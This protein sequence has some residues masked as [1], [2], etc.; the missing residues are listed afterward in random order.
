MEKYSNELN[1]SGGCMLKREA[2]KLLQSALNNPCATFREGQWEAINSVV[3]QNKKVL[4]IQRTGWGKSAVYFIASKI[5]RDRG[6]GMSVIISPLLA[7]MRN[8]VEAAQRLGIS[9]VTLNSSN[10]YD[11]ESIQQRIFRQEVDCLLI[12]PE[13]LGNE[14]F[15]NE[16]LQ[17]I[18]AH[19]ALMVVDEAHC[20]SD[21][22]H[23]FRPDYRRIVGILRRMPPNTPVLCTTATANNRVIQDIQ[24]QIGQ[25]EIQRGSLIR[26]TLHL[27]TLNMP[28][29][30]ERLTWL[31]QA[32]RKF[33][34]TGIVYTLTTRDAEKVAE[35][36][37]SNGINAVAYYSGITHPDFCSSDDYR[38]HLEQA[39]QQN[40]LKVLVATSALGMGYDKPDI[41]FVIHY[42]MPN[43]V[44]GYYQQVGRAGRGVSHALGVL[45][46][47]QEDE[48]IQAFFRNN[49]FPT[50]EEINLVL[51]ALEQSDGLRISDLQRQLNLKRGTIDKVLKFLNL[52]EPAPIIKQKAYW[53]RTVHAYKLD[54]KRIAQLTEQRIKEWREMQNYLQTNQCKMN[55]LQSVLDDCY[56]Q[57]CGKCD[58]CLGRSVV[59]ITIDPHILAQAQ[60]FLRQSEIVIVPRKQFKTAI[61][62]QYGFSGKIPDLLRNEQGRILARWGEEGWGELVE[63]GEQEGYFSDELVEAMAEMILKRWKPMPTPR[64]LCAVPSLRHPTLVVDF[65]QRLAHRLN[66]PFVDC[67]QK[68]KDNSPQKIQNNS[69][70]QCQNLDGVFTVKDNL[71]KTPA[72]LIDDMSDSGW[73]FT[74]VGALLKQFGVQAVYPCALASTATQDE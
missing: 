29:A 28:S 12:S 66:L 74:V 36:L 14:D 6:K 33:K 17:P 57:R 68:V 60:R 13:R 49:A 45:M 26:E 40:Q 42:Q 58:S 9:A 5:L 37:F 43:S 61:Y 64:W 35:W 46:G 59:S 51:H 3:N 10:Q 70:H 34:G 32:I 31:L 73:T 41:S 7:L 19:I 8:Q 69:Y 4:V 63:R 55:F 67:I 15:I 20:I 72:L 30:S 23:D 38:L 54:L 1:I 27:Q 39:L 53:Y 62:P 22:G 71:P 47:G 44:I 56:D 65:A 18:S 48:R 21:W 50:E 24:S 25:I 52:E 16:V 11:W 2:E